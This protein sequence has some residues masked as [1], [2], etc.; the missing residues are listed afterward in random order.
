MYTVEF[1]KRGLPHAHILLWL[2]GDCKLR[3]CTDIDKIISAELPDRKLYPKLFEAV[4]SFMI[5]GPCGDINHRSPCMNAG[6]CTK[7]YPKG[8][9]STT[10]VDEDGYP[11]YKRRDSGVSFE[12]N[13]ATIDSRYVVPYNPHLLVRYGGHI[14]VEYCNKSNSI[15]YLFKYVNKGHDR[16]TIGVSKKD[17][18]TDKDEPVDE[19]QQY[20]DCRYVSPCESVWRIFKFDIHHKWPSVMKLTFHLENE[21]S[22]TFD[23]DEDIDEVVERFRANQMYAEGRDL[24]YSEFPTRFRYIKDERRWQLRQRGEQIGRLQYTPPGVGNLFYMRLLLNV[25]K[26]CQ[27]YECLRTINGKKHNSFQEACDALGLLSDDKEFIDV[28]KD[29]GE[30]Y[31]GPQLRKLFVHLMT[32]SSMKDPGDVWSATWKL[33]SDDIVY[34]RR[35]LLKNPGNYN[36]VVEVILNCL[37]LCLAN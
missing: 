13:G 35:R 20:Y 29:S 12:K 36:L 3:T 10:T 23:D 24:T 6:K 4:T 37:R 11:K 22:V 8:F 19:I 27:G 32:M 15:K 25:Q 34:N 33:L 26:G 7:Y 21:Q 9:Q 31:S 18:T 17:N 2:S 5:H 1:Q 28:I 14:N 30:L 16:S